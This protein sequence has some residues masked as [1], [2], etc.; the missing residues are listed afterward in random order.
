MEKNQQN[1]DLRTQED[2]PTIPFKYNKVKPG[3]D[4]F[5]GNFFTLLVLFI[6]TLLFYRSI[7][8]QVTMDKIESVALLDNFSSSQVLLLF[9]FMTLMMIERMLYRTRTNQSLQ[10]MGGNDAWITNE[11]AQHTLT[12][13]LMIYVTLVLFVHIQCGFYFPIKQ[14]IKLNNNLSLL[15]YYMLWVLHLVYASLQIKHGYPQQPYKHAFMR[16]TSFTTVLKFRVYRAVPFLWEMKVIIDWTVTNTCLDLF[17][18][19]RLDD[20]FNYVYYNKYQSD[21]RRSRPEFEPRDFFEKFTQGFC[22]AFSLICLILAP[23]LL[24]SGINPIKMENPVK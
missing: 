14:G 4:Y 18:W 24:F 22:F 23:V 7:T 11:W 20:A 8:G 6:Y 2:T 21:D 3:Q 9:L 15:F 12:M 1:L 16:D 17:Q 5:S 13:K 10:N 19:F